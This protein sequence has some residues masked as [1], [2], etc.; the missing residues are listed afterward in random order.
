M[1]DNEFP[2]IGRRSSS[3]PV[4]GGTS[5]APPPSG[6]S[7]HFPVLQQR[8]QLSKMMPPPSSSGNQK[9]FQSSYT[10][11]TSPLGNTPGVLVPPHAALP[12]HKVGLS[13]KEATALKAQAVSSGHDLYVRD[14][15]PTRL[16]HLEKPSVRPKPAG[17]YNKTAKTGGNLGL[18]EAGGTGNPLADHQSR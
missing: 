10:P 16:Q 18:V 1:S 5:S 15:N 4:R 6:S 17:L 14:G 9:R 2:N 7:H 12:P 13:R 3:P 11:D 8:A